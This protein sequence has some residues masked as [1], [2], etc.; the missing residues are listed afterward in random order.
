M[1]GHVWNGGRTGEFKLHCS[2]SNSLG[3]TRKIYIFQS[4]P[5]KVANATMLTIHFE[6]D[7][8]DIGVLSLHQDSN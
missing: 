5:K 7:K 1:L 8:L 6:A 3:N 2:S 4:N